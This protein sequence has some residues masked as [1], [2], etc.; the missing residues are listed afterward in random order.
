MVRS[1]SQANATA[2]LA[3]PYFEDEDVSVWY[4]LPATR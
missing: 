4:Y 3:N 1:L 2:K